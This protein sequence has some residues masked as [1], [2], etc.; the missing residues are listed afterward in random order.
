MSLRYYIF[1]L[2]CATSIALFLFLLILFTVDPNT[3][4]ILQKIFFFSS[5]FIVLFGTISLVIFYLRILI[6]NRELIFANLKPA[7]RQAFLL[8][9]GIVV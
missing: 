5:L 1:L 4:D 2:F 8:S 3:A 9:C 6:S 7:L